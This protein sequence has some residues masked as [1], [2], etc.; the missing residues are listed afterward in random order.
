M[1]VENSQGLWMVLAGD[2]A[3]LRFSGLFPSRISVAITLQR[4]M[5][6]PQQEARWGWCLPQ[7]L[8][9][10]VDSKHPPSA[11]PSS[12]AAA[13]LSF[14]LNGKEFT[15]GLTDAAIISGH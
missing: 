12:Q 3:V 15:P 2:G 13:G 7:Q 10:P 5:T 6:R 8:R 1:S 11:V 14:R 9:Q 4:T